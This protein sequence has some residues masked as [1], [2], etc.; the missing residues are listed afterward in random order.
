[1]D[2]LSYLNSEQAQAAEGRREALQ[3]LARQ[4]QWEHRLGDLRPGAAEAKQAA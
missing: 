3:W 2:K 1:M 4:L